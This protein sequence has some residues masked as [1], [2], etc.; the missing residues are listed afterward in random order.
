MSAHGTFDFN[1]ECGMRRSKVGFHPRSNH[2]KKVVAFSEKK[3]ITVRSTKLSFRQ[4]Q[5]EPHVR[6]M[7]QET[8]G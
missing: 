2:W 5:I 7:S 8:N 1:E 6:E 3:K 4:W